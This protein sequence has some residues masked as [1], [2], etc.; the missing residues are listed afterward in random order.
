M[1]TTYVPVFF[2]T[3]V[4]W[5]FSFAVLQ[6][7]VYAQAPEFNIA[8]TITIADGESVDGDIMSLDEEKGTLVR[9]K[10]PY[11]NKMYGVLV[12]KPQIVYKTTTDIPISRSGNAYINVTNIGGEIK[13]GDF[14]TSSQIA[15]KGQKGGDSGGYMVG[16]ALENWDGNSGDNIDF[17]GNS[18]RQGRV[19]T[20]IGVGPASPVLVKAI[21]GI[22]GTLRQLAQAIVYNVGAS[23]LF[24][25]L[26]RY[27]LAVIVAL[28]SI[29][30][31]FRMFGKNVSKGIEA[32]G[33]NPLAK[34]S[35]QAMII[36]N[37]ALIL[38]VSLGG[39]LLALV[40]ISL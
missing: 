4:F 5:L 2:L 26:I 11:D 22:L 23:R 1:K 8:L 10:V 33:R 17:N 37:V 31:S 32:I 40:I 14:I 7:Q 36:M 38:L 35:I 39:V 6:K 16:V 12:E 34:A 25:R 27:I 21:G 29:Y 28:T 18:Y 19:L 30:M 13:R 15:G 9:S 20:A 24:D 3:L